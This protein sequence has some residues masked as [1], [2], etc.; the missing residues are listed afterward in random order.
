M[1]AITIEVNEFN[2][3]G[4]FLVPGC[5][6]D[7]IATLNGENNETFN[8]TVVQN[9]KVLA[10]NAH[11]SAT[12]PGADPEPMRSV[13]LLAVPKE[14]EAINLAAASGRPRFVLRAYGDDSTNLSEGVTLAELRGKIHRADPFGDVKTVALN[15]PATQPSD[16]A[17]GW[18]TAHTRSI[19]AIRGGVESDVTVQLS[20]RE[21]PLMTDTTSEQYKN[22]AHD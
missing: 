11:L 1:R 10:V 13:T 18:N 3:V 17:A 4:G 14:A 5:H 19:K 16:A 22:A 15:K 12:G 2:G 8:R 20:N 9:V 6:V 21:A 7:V